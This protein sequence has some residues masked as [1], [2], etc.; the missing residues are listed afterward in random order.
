M[1]LTTY[2]NF[3]GTCAQA[4]R[5]YEQHLGGTIVFMMTHGQSPEASPLGPEWKDAVLHAR[6]D[7]GGTALLGADILTAE[8][9]RSAY[10]TIDVDDDAEAE[11]IF[12][13]L[14]DGGQV[15]MK[16]EETFFASR[17]GQ[18]R[19]RFGIN[20][21]VLHQRPAPPAPPS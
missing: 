19:D 13:A 3:A 8:P 12:H 9:M 11:R 10:L 4:F 20:W 18:V 2:V 5:Y 6:I 21:M 15:L 7:L 17:F 1:R 14:S 16:M